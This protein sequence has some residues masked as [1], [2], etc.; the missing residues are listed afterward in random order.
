MN[1][2]RESLWPALPQET[3]KQM[4]TEYGAL[5]EDL[6]KSFADAE[7]GPAAANA[8]EVEGVLEQMLGEIVQGT[9]ASA[10]ELA[11]KYQQQLDALSA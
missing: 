11:D 3:A 10:E 4:M 6:K 2:V 7:P 8:G 1:R 9:D 5:T